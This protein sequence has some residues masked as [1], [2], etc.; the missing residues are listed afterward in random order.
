MDIGRDSF[1]T[2]AIVDRHIVKSAAG[3]NHLGGSR[4][5]DQLQRLLFE[6]GYNFTTSYERSHVRRMKEQLCYVSLDYDTDI[7]DQWSADEELNNPDLKRTYR[8]SADQVVD[9]KHSRFNAPE[10]LF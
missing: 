5:T 4:I 6:R 2:I 7:A 1:T 9:I 8:V 10:I 3:R